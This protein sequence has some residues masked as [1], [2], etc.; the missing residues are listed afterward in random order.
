MHC[1][2]NFE[3]DL[4]KLIIVGLIAEKYNQDETYFPWS[5]ISSIFFCLSYQKINCY[6]L[7]VFRYFI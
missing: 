2:E 6:L 1:L 7:S 4:R 3:S 5:T